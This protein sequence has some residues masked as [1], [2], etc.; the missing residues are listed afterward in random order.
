MCGVK[1]PGVIGADCPGANRVARAAST[2][3]VRRPSL[4]PDT[5][6]PN[7]PAPNSQAPDPA[8]P[9]PAAPGP[10]APGP[11]A[12]GPAAPD[13]AAPGPAA[14]GP[15]APGPAAPGPTAPGPGAPG[16][17]EHGEPACHGDPRVVPASPARCGAKARSGTP[18]RGP[19]MTNGRCRMHGGRS[20]G[21][22]TPEGKARMI[23]ANTKHGRCGMASAP[24][25][26][27]Q[28]YVRSVTGRLRLLCTA[29]LLRAYLPPEMAVRLGQH[30]PELSAPIHP[31]E[32]AFAQQTAMPSDSLPP[33]SVAGRMQGVSGGA[34]SPASEA[35]AGWRGGERRW[36]ARRW[37]A[38][39]WAKRRWAKRRWA[40]RRGRG[41]R[42]ARARGGA[43]GGTPR[44]GRA[45]TMEGGNRVRALGE[46]CGPCRLGRRPET[47]NLQN[48]QLPHATACSAGVRDAES[49][50][51]GQA[52]ARSPDAGHEDRGIRDP[53]ICRP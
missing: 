27:R 6:S 44:G 13:P 45:R 40:E 36:V 29:I 25:R 24:Q 49:R 18:C 10:T 47:Q 32:L 43:I 52:D 50:D 41:V 8:A 42:A 14:P 31:S 51:A 11:T 20:T 12:P 34:G 37:V 35:G 16:P 5:L 26:A 53:G 48:A 2:A 30:P 38:R 46:A 33:G 17:A 21:P 28:R 23:A 4:P 9:G 7:S 15:T 3:A 39:R 1:I 22:R 19:A